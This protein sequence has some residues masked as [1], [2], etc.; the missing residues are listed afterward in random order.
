MLT[1][2]PN[3]C[4]TGEKRKNW[5]VMT[6][7]DRERIVLVGQAISRPLSNHLLGGCDRV[8]SASCV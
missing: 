1:R 4:G 5:I 3:V 7:K 2:L 6:V 8:L